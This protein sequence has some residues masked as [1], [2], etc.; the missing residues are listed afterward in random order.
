MLQINFSVFKR[1]KLVLI[2]LRK[3]FIFKSRVYMELVTYIFSIYSFSLVLISM[4]NAST[5][6]YLVVD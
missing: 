2:I 3:F 6:S 5:V 1:S 4:Q